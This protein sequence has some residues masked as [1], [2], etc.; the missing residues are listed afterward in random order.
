MLQ[1]PEDF[2]V[3]LL[4]LTELVDHHDASRNNSLCRLLED[5]IE[6]I[7]IILC[8]SATPV[9][10]DLVA[11]LL[12]KL[13]AIE[14]TS[15]ARIGLQ[16]LLERASAD[17]VVQPTPNLVL[18]SSVPNRAHLLAYFSARGFLRCLPNILSRTTDLTRSSQYDAGLCWHT[19]QRVLSPGACCALSAL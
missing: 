4:L 10:L 9:L 13:C 5:N 8:Q 15:A 3:G 17:S 11:L 2:L 6:S 12:W 14:D 1:C 16:A 19:F 7:V 18:N